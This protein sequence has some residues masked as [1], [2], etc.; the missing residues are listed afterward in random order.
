MNWQEDPKQMERV[1]DDQIAFTWKQ[2]LSEEKDVPEKLN[3]FAMVKVRK[4]AII[5]FIA[6]R[7]REIKGP[8]TAAM[9]TRKLLHEL[10]SPY[11]S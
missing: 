9:F 4:W 1:E 8:F 3:Y 5:K 6:S 10:F 2:F 7:N 11:R